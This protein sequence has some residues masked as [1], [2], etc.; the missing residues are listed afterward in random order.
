[1]PY[2][3]DC[4]LH[5]Q[6]INATWEVVACPQGLF[7]DGVTR[8]CTIPTNSPSCVATCPEFGKY[9]LTWDGL[10]VL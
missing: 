5:Y 8:G 4:A 2:P 7:F 9:N 10:A 6:C 3:L 1:M